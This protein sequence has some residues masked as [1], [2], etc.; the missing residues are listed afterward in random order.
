M[1]KFEFEKNWKSK[2]AAASDV[3]MLLW[4][5]WK[6]IKQQVISINWKYKERSLYVPNI[7]VNRMNGV[8]SRGE[9][10]DWTP[11]PP[12]MPS[13]NFFYL[14]PSGVNK[15]QVLVYMKDI[16][17]RAG[18]FSPVS[19]YWAG[20]SS[21]VKPAGAVHV[22]PIQFQPGL[23]RPLFGAHGVIWAAEKF[24]Y[25]ICCYYKFSRAKF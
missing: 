7:L 20:V 19:A 10:S 6:P 2:R 12:L 9:G 18:I 24:G 8:K 5:P 15:K 13:C 14:I 22:I 1:F 23:R 17:A 11:P 4:L 21:S 25:H 16:S 3:I